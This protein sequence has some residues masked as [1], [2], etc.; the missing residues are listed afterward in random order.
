[1][2]A[3]LASSGFTN[4]EIIK[5]CEELAGKPRAEINFVVLNEAIKAEK[6]DC[7]WL[8]EGLE[9]IAKNFGGTVELLDLQAHDLTYT[10]ERIAAC[11]V[12]FCFGGQTDYLK[13]VFQKT[14][15]VKILPEILEEKVWVGSSAGSCVLCHKE[16]KETS[17]GVFE[18][19]VENRHYLELLPL[20]FL[21]HYESKWFPQLTKEVA[22]REGKMTE[23][24]VYLMSDQAAL[25]VRGNLEQPEFQV[26][27]E[28]YV[29]VKGGQVVAEKEVRAAREVHKKIAKEYFEVIM[30]GQKTFEYR[31]N[32][33]V[34]EPGDVLVLDEYEY[35]DGQARRA[36]GRSIRKRV[37]YVG[38]TKDFDWL[39]RED[40]KKAFA[41]KG[42]QII[43]LLDE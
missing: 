3:I 13:E 2:K 27:G 32:D 43:S 30:A 34:C 39:E 15:F 33:F 9:E 24:P 29:V 22:I 42:A 36:T 4:E 25:I 5:A 21:P 38:R 1:M 40:V 17:V 18:E 20:F 26:I 23:L 37:G 8:I 7:R 16:S 31:A 41:E 35:N 6:G 10:R 14:G 19:T 12:V 28:G 11:D